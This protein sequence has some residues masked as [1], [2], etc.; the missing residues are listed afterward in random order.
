MNWIKNSIFLG[1]C[2]TLGMAFAETEQEAKIKKLIEPR[3]GANIKVDSV[4]KT[5]YGGLFEVVTNGDVF[6]TDETAQ[7]LV[8]GRVVETKTYQDLTKAR[9][10]QLSAIKFSDLPFDSAMKVVKGDGKRVFAVFADPHCPYC[11]NL[12]R[13]LQKIDNA[14]I[15]TF[16]LNIVTEQSADKSKDIWCAPDRYKAWDEWMLNGKLPPAAPV[17]CATP[18]DQILALGKKIKVI[19]TPT[20]Y[21]SDGSRTG[22]IGDVKTLEAKLAAIK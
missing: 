21:F 20:V 15:Y 22:S 12:H 9:V 11:K 18:N 14:T 17:N 10:D 3:M 13:I 19:G 1:A 8:I 4:T 5:P 2:L 16:M 6:Y 7:Y